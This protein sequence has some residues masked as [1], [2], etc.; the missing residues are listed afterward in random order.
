MILFL[1]SHSFDCANVHKEKDNG[2]FEKERKLLA[3]VHYRIGPGLMLFWI[4]LPLVDGCKLFF[5]FITHIINMHTHMLVCISISSVV[6]SYMVWGI[7]PLGMCI[8]ID[9]SF[10]YLY[11]NMFHV[12]FDVCVIFVICLFLV[13]CFVYL[14]CLR[15]VM[16]GR[17]GRERRIEMWKV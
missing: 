1:H 12:M 8:L 5:K 14:S 11:I 6:S 15:Y 4:L 7:F 10:S 16:F 13:S 17:L 2:G 3:L 9:I